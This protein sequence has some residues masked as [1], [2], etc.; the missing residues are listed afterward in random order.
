MALHPAYVTADEAAAFVGIDDDDDDTELDR[1]ILAASRAIDR[2]CKRQFGKVDTAE[3]RFYTPRWS[4]RR[5][6]WVVTVDDFQSTTSLA[7]NLDLDD[8]GTFDDAVTGYRK[9]P[10]NAQGEGFPWTELVLPESANSSLCGDEGEV[11]V[12]A[13]YGWIAV[14]EAV[15]EAALL[16]ANRLFKRSKAPFG[17]AGSPE[18]GSEVRLLAKVD[19]DVAVTLAYYR[20]KSM[21][22]G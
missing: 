9:L 15:K 17:V 1:A 18:A 8:N 10:L 2:H 14:P 6:R 13:L 21:V 22:V 12:T 7:V 16:Q 4:T 11:S 3:E 5:C 20:R 19:P